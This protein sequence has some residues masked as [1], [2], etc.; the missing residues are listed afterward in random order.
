MFLLISAIPAFAGGMKGGLIDDDMILP[1]WIWV[2]LTHALGVTA[3]IFRKLWLRILAG[4]LYI[5][6]LLIPLV[7][8]IFFPPFALLVIPAILFLVFMIIRKR[9]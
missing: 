3:F 5:P 4:V 8:A 1:F 9:K 2:V 7:P 6:M